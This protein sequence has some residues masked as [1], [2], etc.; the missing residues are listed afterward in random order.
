MVLVATPGKISVSATFAPLASLISTSWGVPGYW[1]SKA[2]GNPV[3]GAVTV[4]VGNWTFWATIVTVAPPPPP[5][6]WAEAGALPDGAA[7]DGSAE[8]PA[9]GS[10]LGTGV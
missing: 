7:P 9:D 2:R 1:L 5:D 10:E 4:G 3:E 8:V 6:G